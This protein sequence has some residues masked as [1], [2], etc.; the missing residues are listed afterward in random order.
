MKYFICSLIAGLLLLNSIVA[1]AVNTLSAKEKK[2][3]FTLLFNGLN[4]D[5]WTT[6]DGKPVPAGW[7]VSDGLIT[8]VLDGKGGD[9]ISVKEYSDFDLKLEYK[10]APGCNSG[11]KYYFTKYENGGNL[12]MEFQIIDNEAGEDIHKE[13]HLT[14]SFYDVLKPAVVKPTIHPAGQWNT[15]W[16]VAKGNKVAHWLNGVKILSFVRGSKA[17]TDAVA[18]SKFNKTSPAFGT[19][20]KGYILLQE[21]GG[22]VSFKNI[23]IKSL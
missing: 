8:A 4:T 12:G 1:Q 10:I 2:Q 19:V 6:T 16:I 22:V 7:V 20:N 23:K 18:Q 15:V 5:A 21:H 9:I 14:G 17:F 11:V 3:G 13:N